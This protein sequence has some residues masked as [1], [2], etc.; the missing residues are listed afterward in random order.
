VQVFNA[1]YVVLSSL[2]MAFSV[3]FLWYTE[4]PE[5]RVGLLRDKIEG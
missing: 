1:P 3:F 5:V 2:S 4:L